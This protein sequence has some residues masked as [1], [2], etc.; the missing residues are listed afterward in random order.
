MTRNTLAR[1]QWLKVGAVCACNPVWLAGCG[2]A[3]TDVSYV[4]QSALIDFDDARGQMTWLATTAQ[5]I[6]RLLGH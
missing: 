4:L 5:D 1:R 3:D 2:D 6:R